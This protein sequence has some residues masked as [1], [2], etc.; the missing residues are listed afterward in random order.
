M[1][2]ILREIHGNPVLAGAQAGKATLARLLDLATVA[3]ATSTTAWFWD[4]EGVDVVSASFVRE[5]FTSLQA[6]LRAQRSPLFPVVANAS[7]DVQE[8]LRIMFKEAGHAMIACAIDQAG[9]I[10]DV[11]LIG[12]LD[13]YSED[14]FAMVLNRGETDAKELMDAQPPERKIGQTAWNNRLASL[15]ALGI[16]VELPQGRAKRYRAAIEGA[17]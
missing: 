6:L 17:D 10:R 1:R 13:R 2:T 14:T 16:L 15:A 9:K 3:R 12:A 8:D 5:C 7:P 4:F 11:S